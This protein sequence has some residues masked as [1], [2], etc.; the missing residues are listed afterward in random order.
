MLIVV[1]TK[2]AGYLYAYEWRKFST[3]KTASYVR[4]DSCW[5]G[6]LAGTILY[7]RGPARI[8]IYSRGPSV[9]VRLWIPVPLPERHQCRMH[10]ELCLYCFWKS[11]SCMQRRKT[12]YIACGLAIVGLHLLVR[13]PNTDRVRGYRGQQLPKIAAWIVRAN[14]PS[15]NS[16]SLAANDIAI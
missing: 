16:V 7:I 15:N 13:R 5:L 12:M 9:Q 3:D 4:T 8:S 10:H 6:S 2:A 14:P 11:Y 1:R